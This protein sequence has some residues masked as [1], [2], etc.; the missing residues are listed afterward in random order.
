MRLQIDAVTTIFVEIMSIGT[1]LR[2][3][4]TK[5]TKTSVVP[6]GILSIN[7]A[8]DRLLNFQLFILPVMISI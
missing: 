3:V 5:L 2:C 6:S 1:S 7:H 4:T 8:D